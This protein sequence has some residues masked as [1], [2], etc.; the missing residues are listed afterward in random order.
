MSPKK[1]VCVCSF[2]T[3]LLQ[4]A[5]LSIFFLNSKSTE[6]C[7]KTHFQNNQIRPRHSYASFSSLATYWAEDRMRVVFKIISHQAPIHLSELH[8]YTPSRQLI[9]SADIRVFRIPSFRTKPSGQCFFSYQA[10]LIWNQLPISG[11]HSISVSFWNSLFKNL[12]FSPI[13]LIY[14]CVCLFVLYVLNFE[15]RYI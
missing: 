3:R 4:I 2:K 11:H 12:F 15:N 5:V 13:A 8:L 14:V 10:A 1:V 9:S 6:Q 7:C